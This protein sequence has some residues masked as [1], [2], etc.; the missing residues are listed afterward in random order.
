[1]KKETNKFAKA[2]QEFKIKY[3]QVTT[4]DLLTFTIGWQEALDSLKQ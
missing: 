4:S 1:M 3:P 2:I